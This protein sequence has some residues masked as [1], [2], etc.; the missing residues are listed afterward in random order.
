MCDVLLQ[1]VGGEGGGGRYLGTDP[2]VDIE[3][4]GIERTPAPIALPHVWV[5]GSLLRRAVANGG[6]HHRAV[7]DGGF[8]PGRLTLHWGTPGGGEP[9]GSLLRGS[10]SRYHAW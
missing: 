10:Q 5:G 7:A 9:L 8:P 4:L 6:L 2:R 1:M 3:C